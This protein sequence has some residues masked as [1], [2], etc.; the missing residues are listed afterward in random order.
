MRV[1]SEECKHTGQQ[2]NISC[3]PAWT[4]DDNSETSFGPADMYYFE[5]GQLEGDGSGLN[6]GVQILVGL[7]I[8]DLACGAAIQVNRHSEDQ[9]MAVLVSRFVKSVEFRVSSVNMSPADWLHFLPLL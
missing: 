9:C 8:G 7:R 4:E 6:C 1:N 2:L 3:Y 5:H